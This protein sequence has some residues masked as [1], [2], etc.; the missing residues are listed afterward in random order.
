KPFLALNLKIDFNDID[1]EMMNNLYLFEPFGPY[2]EQPIFATE[3][4]DI[5]GEVRIVGSK[6][7]SNNRKLRAK[8]NHLR[9]KLRQNGIVFDAIGFN[10]ADKY[11]LVNDL[12][13]NLKFAY[14]I[15]EN[16]WNGSS[17]IQLKIKDILA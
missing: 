17:Y 6:V 7:D 13:S 9:M 11:D 2:N 12:R 8:G 10:L 5:V 1:Q 16:N 14:L 15:E 3:N 4:V